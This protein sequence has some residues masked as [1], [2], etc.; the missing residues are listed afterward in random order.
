MK[1]NPRAWLV[2]LPPVLLLALAAVLRFADLGSRPMHAD[3]AVQAYI[4]ADLL[5]EGKYRYDPSH[6]HGPLPH[7]IN[8]PLMRALGIRKL[9]TLQ[10]WQ[11]RLQP[12]LAGL[13]LA[14]LAGACAG[15]DSR[16]RWRA[17]LLAG[18][19][20]M[21]L[22]FSRM[23][24]HET[25]LALCALAV[26]FAVARWLET[27]RARWLI[28]TAL[29]FGCMH[30]TKE[31]WCIIAFSWAAAAFALWPKKTWHAVRGAGAARIALVATA[32]M[33]ISFLLYSN[34]G[35][36]PGGFADA[37][38]TLFSYRTGG[39]HEKGW[40]YYAVE[41]LGFYRPGGWP[42]GEGVVGLFAIAGGVMA[43][44]RRKNRYVGHHVPALPLFLAVSGAAQVVVYSII[45]YK[46]PWLML[47]PLASFVPLAAHGWIWAL[48]RRPR[49]WRAAACA[50]VVAAGLLA[51]ALVSS[52]KAPTSAAFP[53][54]YV[55]TLPDADAELDRVAR[56]LPADA[57]TAVIGNDYWPLPWYFRAARERTGFFSEAGA[58]SSEELKEFALVIHTGY[59]LDPSATGAGWRVFELRPG[60][61]VS[62]SR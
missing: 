11:F 58:P 51:P 39:G 41:C 28:V 7:F 27:R 13:L 15:G 1:N 32:A 42:V 3:E 47:A 57:M 8:L 53:F 22:Y 48:G 34:F 10:A 40:W 19:A 35:K 55:P 61:F 62:I 54:V 30:A 4:F 60:Y 5:E 45:K 44:R 2:V 21:L 20:P 50:L 59:Q 38:R 9:D 25:L 33:G 31:T 26:P 18:I 16:A 46:T 12:A 14:A 56:A 52:F 17:M 36:H 37:W 6:Y 23:A 24:I 43:W 29:A 49:W